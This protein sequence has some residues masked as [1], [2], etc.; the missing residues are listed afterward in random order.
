MEPGRDP[1]TGPVPVTDPA[2]DPDVEP[3]HRG[4][5]R[6]R[7][8]QITAANLPSLRS[9]LAGRRHRRLRWLRFERRAQEQRS[10]F[11]SGFSRGTAPEQLRRHFRAFGP[12]ATVV[13]DKEK[14]L[15]AIVELQDAAGRQR[16]LDE[17]RHVLEGRRLRGLGATGRHW[18]HGMGA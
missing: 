12:V 7:L 11:V 9:H 5:F 4:G 16:A 6:C 15:F 8:C 17:P 13:M 18:E 3:L 1:V 10:L 14:G 2:A